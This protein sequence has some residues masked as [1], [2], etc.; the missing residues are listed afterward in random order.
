MSDS[1]QEG[2]ETRP[3]K[4]RDVSL[5]MVKLYKEQFGRGPVKARTDWA[6]DDVLVCTLEESLTPAEQN[7]RD[8][9]EHER[10][11]DTRMFFQYASVKE[12]VEPVERITGRT[13]R[14]FISGIDSREDVAMEA[15]ILYPRG[16][17]G[18]SRADGTS[19]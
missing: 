12:F 18:P 14:S 9:D 2:V 19:P 17:E 15:F 16:S 1:V 6:G 11:R 8:M 7:L 13:V 3:S 5:A 4:L 10:L